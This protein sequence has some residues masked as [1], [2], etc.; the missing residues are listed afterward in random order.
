MMY[1]GFHAHAVKIAEA[2]WVSAYVNIRTEGAAG[3]SQSLNLW[4][5][6]ECQNQLKV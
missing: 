2:K 6:T 1:Q 4:T 5:Y 3:I